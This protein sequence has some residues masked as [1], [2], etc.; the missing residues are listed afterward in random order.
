MQLFYVLYPGNKK[1]CVYEAELVS[2]ICKILK[3]NEALLKNL[4][5]IILKNTCGNDVHPKSWTKN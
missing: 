2:V 5:G 4:N 3:T 1:D